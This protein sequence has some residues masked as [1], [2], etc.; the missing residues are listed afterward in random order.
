VSDEP[1]PEV[2]LAASPELTEATVALAERVNAVLRAHRVEALLIGGLA[3]AVHGYVRSTEDLDLG[4][5]TSIQQMQAVHAQLVAAGFN[6]LIRESD[7][8]DPLGGVIDV[9]GPAGEAVQIVNF[10]NSPTQ[11]LPIA[12]KEALAQVGPEGADGR[13]RV[14]PVPHL[15]ALKVYA[16]MSGAA[17]ERARRDVQELLRL[18]PDVNVEEVRALCKRYRLNLD[19]L[20]NS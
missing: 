7:G 14:I 18:N 8:N 4:V 11:G 13:L 5:A 9:D 19:R 2:D 12:I 10:D 1:R 20:L 16:T 17:A 15:I 6:A 3:L